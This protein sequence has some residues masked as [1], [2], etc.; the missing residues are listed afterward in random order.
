MKHSL[1]FL[2]GT[3]AVVAGSSCGCRRDAT[4]SANGHGSEATPVT[5]AVVT[6]AAWDRTVSIVGTLFPKD[7]AAVAS[8]V[9]GQVE[10]TLVDFGDR[11]RSDQELA[12]IDTASYAAQLEQ[13][14]GNLAKAEAN[15]ANA[16][17]NFDRVQRLKNDG[18][19]SASDFDLARAQLDQWEAEL[20]AARGGQAVARLNVQHSRALAP[21]DGGIAQRFVGRGDY[22]HVGTPL[23]NLVNDAVLKFIFQVPERHASYVEKKLP[24]TFNVD[25]YPGESFTGSVY[26]I[27]PAVN[28]ASRSFGVGAL[29]TNTNFRLKANTFA[30]G[31]LVLERGVSTPVVPLESVVSFAGLTKL[32]VIDDNKVARSRTVQVGRIQDGLQE[33]LSGLTPGTI[34]AV[35]GQSRLADGVPVRIQDP[36][37]MAK[38]DEGSNS[39]RAR[40]EGTTHERR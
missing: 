12:N 32:F 39:N 10:R 19:A 8:Q 17:Q 30:R 1:H 6:N 18:I 26:L 16:R 5:V 25:N 20:K 33:V 24:V 36:A 37:I 9:E 23:F 22:V 27:S 35:T 2:A 34:V 4:V 38:A 14:E 28:T 29:V 40:A 7:E 3:L 15:L 11:V 21:F 13:A 31:T